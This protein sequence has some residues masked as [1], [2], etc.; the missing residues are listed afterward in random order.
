MASKPWYGWSHAEIE[1]HGYQFQQG[2]DFYG[3]T[4]G[5]TG[6]QIAL[7]DNAVSD[8]FSAKDAKNQ[9]DTAAKQAQEDFIAAEK[10]M[11]EAMQTLSKIVRA[12]NPA[13]DIILGFGMPIYK[14]S[15]GSGSPVNAPAELSVTGTPNGNILRWSGGGNAPRTSY[16]IEFSTSTSG[17]WTPLGSTMRSTF[18]DTTRKPG[19]FTLYRVIASR[20]NRNPVVSTVVA[21]YPPASM[22]A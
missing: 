18:T 19:Q 9:A 13:P 22:A 16:T 15:G 21:V 12:K 4:I 17:T 7:I 10:K 1:Q 2:A 6:A 3:A 8:F 20:G 5:L 11:I 14:P